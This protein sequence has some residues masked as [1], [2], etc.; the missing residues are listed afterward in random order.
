MN[1]LNIKLFAA[2]VTLPLA[3]AGFCLIYTLM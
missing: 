3:Y 2:T 1:K